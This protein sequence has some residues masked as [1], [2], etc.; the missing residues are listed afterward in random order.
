M[1]GKKFKDEID[2]TWEKKS[3]KYSFSV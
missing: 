2:N 1:G 3:R